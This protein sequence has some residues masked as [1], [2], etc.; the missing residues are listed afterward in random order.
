MN[1]WFIIFELYSG[2]YFFYFH[3]SLAIL[4]D[5]FSISN[6]IHWQRKNK[7]ISKNLTRGA[8]YLLLQQLILQRMVAFMVWPPYNFVL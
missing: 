5:V 3:L 6:T 4:Y 2:L 7:K 8:S 1:F